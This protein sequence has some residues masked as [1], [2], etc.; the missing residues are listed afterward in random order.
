MTAV[1]NSLSRLSP[2]RH[3]VPLLIFVSLASLITGLSVPVMTM[4]ELVFWQHTFSVVTGIQALW[5]ENNR[6]LAGIIFLFSIVFPLVKLFALLVI[7]FRPFSDPVRDRLL[8]AVSQIGKWS[9]LDVF[10]VAVTI[11]IT[12]LSSVMKA[13]P[14]FGLYLFGGSVM[15]AMIVTM[16]V[17]QLARKHEIK[18]ERQGTK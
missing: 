16:R 4:K 12:K 1:K 18:K 11:V 6:V 15:I 14:Q 5:T 10:V 13:E 3:E 17:E 2:G 7:W 8:R 9:M